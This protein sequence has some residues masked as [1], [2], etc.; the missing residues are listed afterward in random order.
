MNKIVEVQSVR[1][2]FATV[3]PLSDTAKPGCQLVSQ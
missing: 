2:S 3:D 1:Y